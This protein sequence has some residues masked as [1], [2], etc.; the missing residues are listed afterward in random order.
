MY[1][2]IEQARRAL[3][4][5]QPLDSTA[6]WRGQFGF[7]CPQL[8]VHDYLWGPNRVVNQGINAILNGY[9]RSESLPAAFYIAPFVADV[10]PTATVT[11]ANFNSTLTEFTNYDEPTR[12]EWEMDGPST[13][14]E[15]INDAVPAMFTIA[16]G[17]QTEIRGAGLFTMSGKGS[18]GGGILVAAAKAPSA[19]TNL[20]DGFEVKIK[21]RLL[22]SSS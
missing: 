22:G 8:G 1:N 5:S 18:S 2:L 4:R 11:A 17:V 21:Y 14:Q 15:L 12:P 7:S 3:G 10:T 16:D 9:F 20:A 19:F 13:A 6:M